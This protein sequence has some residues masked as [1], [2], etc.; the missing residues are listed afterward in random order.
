MYVAQAMAEELLAIE[1]IYLRYRTDPDFLDELHYYFTNYC[2]RPT[3]LTYAD[4]LSQQCGFHIYLKREDMTNIG[5]H[6]INHSIYQ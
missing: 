6:K 2:G 5:A 1:Q 3:A 4:R